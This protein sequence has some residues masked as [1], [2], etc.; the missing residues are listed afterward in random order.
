LATLAE[1]LTELTGLNAA[2]N[3]ITGTASDGGAQE[4]N[5]GST[6]VR[7]A[8]LDALYARKAQVEAAI[9]GLTSGK[10]R[11]TSPLFIR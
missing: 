7:R 10:S 8:D 1:Y 9:L 6:H 3:R 5:Q 11:I 4:Y 2:I